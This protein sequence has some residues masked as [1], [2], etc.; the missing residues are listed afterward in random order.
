[1]RPSPSACSPP[2]ERSRRGYIHCY[3]GV[4]LIH[5]LERGRNS[6]HGAPKPRE[7]FAIVSVY[8]IAI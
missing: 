7:D 6:T 8:S 1:M 5:R 2:G 3:S 4:S